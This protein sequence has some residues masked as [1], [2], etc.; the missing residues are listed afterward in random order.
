MNNVNNIN[1]EVRIL[2]SIDSYEDKETQELTG[3]LISRF[4]Q[5]SIELLSALELSKFLHR[6]QFRTNPDGSRSKYSTHPLR[7]A[8]RAHSF[9][10]DED[11]TIAG[12]LHDT[13]E[14]CSNSFVKDMISATSVGLNIALETELPYFLDN[15][16]SDRTMRAI[17]GVTVPYE[18]ESITD[19]TERNRRYALHVIEATGADVDVLVT[20][21]C[22]YLDNAGGVVNYA[23]GSKHYGLAQ[24]LAR[25]YL[26]LADPFLDTLNDF[27][28]DG[29]LGQEAYDLLAF[30]VE[31]VRDNLKDFIV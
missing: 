8:L 10:G 18:I 29:S 19:R 30:E 16:F 22:D 26:P 31:R 13:I 23:R 24:K 6:G 25:K 21:L 9:T 3:K 20:K 12:L 7:V 2:V 11:L 5:P 27:L 15:I 28:H 14:D 1:E 17:Q 4:N